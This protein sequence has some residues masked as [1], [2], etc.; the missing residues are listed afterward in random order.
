MIADM[1]KIIDDVETSSNQSQA[2][3]M[4]DTNEDTCWFSGHGTRQSID[5][6]LR[7]TL[8]LQRI[9]IFFQR[10][11]H[12]TK[13]KGCVTSSGKSSDYSMMEF[14]DG[15]GMGR[16][17]INRDADHIRIVL[18]ESADIYGRYCIY[19]ISLGL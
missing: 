7:Q 10:G 3:C 11:F 12:C 16:L 18:E 15:G 6:Y 17:D 2:W 14:H 5:I 1:K 8:R 13:G 19:R 4:F 9:E